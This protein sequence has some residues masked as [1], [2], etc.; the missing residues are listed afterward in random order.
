MIK[1]REREKRAHLCTFNRRAN[2]IDFLHLKLCLFLCNT[3][4]ERLHLGFVQR[5]LFL[6]SVKP[7]TH[8]R[9][10]HQVDHSSLQRVKAGCDMGKSH[11]RSCEDGELLALQYTDVSVNMEI[12]LHSPAPGPKTMVPPMNQAR[13]SLPLKPRLSLPLPARQSPPCYPVC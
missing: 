2:A 4:S 13:C 11:S 12:P 5:P 10:S 6:G 9:F 8:V 7:I 3:S 1:M